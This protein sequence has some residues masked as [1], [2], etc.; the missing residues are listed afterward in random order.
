MQTLYP[1]IKESDSI[2]FASPIY[3]F[4][5]SS[6]TKLFIDRCYA[7]GGGQK[8]VFSGKRFGILLAYADPDPFISGAVNAL[9]TFQDISN[10]L[11]AEISGMVY[12]S[13]R[14]AGE[15]KND[16]NLM[17]KAYQLGVQLASEA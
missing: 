12:G 13:A 6:Q 15:I 7:V 14:E 9:R 17:K 2:V 8:N 1:K 3:W 10:Y 11:G 16:Q 5:V 4:T